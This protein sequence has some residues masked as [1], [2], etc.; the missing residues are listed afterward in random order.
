MSS[1]AK[2]KKVSFDSFKLVQKEDI[3]KRERIN[4]N[5]NLKSIARNPNLAITEDDIDDSPFFDFEEE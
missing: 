4:T 2:I 1:T 5:K 3:N